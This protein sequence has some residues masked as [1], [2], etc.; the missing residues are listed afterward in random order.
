[1]GLVVNNARH[2]FL[3]GDNFV[4]ITIDGLVKEIRRD[5]NLPTG[6]PPCP[7]SKLLSRKVTCGPP[8]PRQVLWQV[9]GNY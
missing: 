3:R 5:Q 9:A 6:R 4:R 1:M 2:I 7:R 8:T